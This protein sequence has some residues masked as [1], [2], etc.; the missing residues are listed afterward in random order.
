MRFEGSASVKVAVEVQSR[1][2][3]V[4]RLL[5]DSHHHAPK[6]PDVRQIYVE[7]L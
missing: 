3:G 7:S 1:V 2:P 6:M 4:N 5:R